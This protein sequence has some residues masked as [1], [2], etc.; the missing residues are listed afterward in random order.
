MRPDTPDNMTLRIMQSTHIEGMRNYQM[1][2]M[3]D[4]RIRPSRLRT[5]TL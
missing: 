3:F 4:E 1:A 5:G 2:S